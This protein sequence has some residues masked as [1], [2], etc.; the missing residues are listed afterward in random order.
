MIGR[1]RVRT[2]TLCVSSQIGCAMGCGFCET[3]QMGLIRSLTADEIV[4]QWFHATHTL[5]M[6]PSNIVFMGMGEPLDNLD[7]VLDAVAVLKD[8]RGP[9]VPIS[10]VTIST[11][12]RVDGLE[13]LGQK[14]HEP[15]WHRLNL[16]LSLNAPN[17]TVRDALMPINRKYNLAELQRALKAF[18]L[19]GGGKICVEY[20][21]IPGVNDAPEHV[22]EV[23]EFL[24]P[25]NEPHPKWSPRAMINL[26]PYNPRRN[27]PWPAPSEEQ[28]EAF[29]GGLIRRGVF[30]KRR[31]T[32][33][34]SMMGA[35]GQ[36]GN[37]H[38]RGRKPVSLTISAE[39]SPA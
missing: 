34:R 33:G 18:P 37:E 5:S 7:N 39:N 6:R 21:L 24:A 20:V 4:A 22:D 23:A 3:A 30:A 19:Y 27:S 1:S 15:G 9:G 26:I 11:V 36:L 8:Q 10:K 12:G 17:D 13:K 29:L 31:R 2:Y 14:L 28:I 16:A 35:C 32:K 38:I 25:I